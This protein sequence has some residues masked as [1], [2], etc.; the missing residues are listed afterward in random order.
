MIYLVERLRAIVACVMVALWLP[1]SMHCLLE[2]AGWLPKDESCAAA[3]AGTH[4]QEDGCQFE[5]GGV[6]FQ[7]TKVTIP[8]F[9]FLAVLLR[10]LPE[11]AELS[12]GL[13][14]HEPDILVELVHAWQF[15][16]RTAL[17]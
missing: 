12:S 15:T 1:A 16:Y 5:S 17:P 7:A 8:S 14:S 6:Q 3:P 4:D 13:I 11:P 9:D 10:H 2:D